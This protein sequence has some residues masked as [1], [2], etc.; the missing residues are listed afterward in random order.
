VSGFMRVF[1]LVFFLVVGTALVMGDMGEGIM[2]VREGMTAV[3]TCRTLFHL[4]SPA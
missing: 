2:E 1:F 3:G 4:E